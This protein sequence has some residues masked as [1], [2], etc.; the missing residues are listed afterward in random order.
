MRIMAT[1]RRSFHHLTP[2]TFMLLF[3]SLVRPHLEY[4]APVWSPRLKQ[5][6]ERLE[7]LQRRATKMVPALKNLPYPKRLRKLKLLSLSYRKLRGEMITTFKITNG[8]LDVEPGIFFSLPPHKNT[9]GHSK[10]LARERARTKK[11]RATFATL[12]QGS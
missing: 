12:P 4:A 11:M 7:G 2:E 5:D 9:R 6:R 10:K 3:K 1:I 8:L